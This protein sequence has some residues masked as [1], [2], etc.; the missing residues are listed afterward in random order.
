MP[1]NPTA[2]PARGLLRALATALVFVTFA[3]AIAGCGSSKTNGTN[4]DPATVVPATA[5]LYAG[6]IVRP[7][8]PLKASARAAGQALTHQ[9]NP[10]LRLLGALQTPGSPAL[11]YKHDVQPWL[12]PNA[13]AFLNATSGSGEADV[14]RLLSLLQQGLLGGSSKSTFPFGTTGVQGAIVLDTSDSEEASSFLDS[15][16]KHAGAHASSYRGVSYQATAGDVALGVVGH[17]A[18]IGSEA[19]LHGVIDTIQ[20]G[21]ALVHATAYSKLLASAPSGVLAHVYSNVT[22]PSHGAAGGSAAHGSAGLLSLLAGNR[23][24]NVSL[25]P[26]ANS[27]ALD[28]DTLS[29]GSSP[30]AGG[31]LSSS[32][33]ASRALGELP[34]ESWF[35]VGLADAGATLG[36]DAQ[37]LQSLASL[38]DTLTGSDSTGESPSATLSVKGL[39]EGFLA[40]LRA[41]GSGSAEAKRDFASWMGSA[42]IF[43]SGSG[44]LELQGGVVIAS[45]D[46]ARS[47]AAVGKLAAKLREDGSSVTKASVPGTEAAVEARLSGLPVVLFIAAGRAANGQSK[48]VM[49]LGESSVTAAL[50]PSSTLSGSASYGTASAA[51]GEDIQPSLTIDFPTLLSLLEGVGLNEDPTIAPFVPYLRSLTT[52]AGGGKSLGEDIERF[53]LVLTLAPSGG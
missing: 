8:E 30:A 26:S 25:V 47:R 51:L 18:V 40:P 41:L 27:I 9:A 15:Q 23:P 53:R 13:G 44:L 17:F 46:P 16:A 14:D 33:E 5:S 35:A 6:A 28:A 12:G 48:F 42:G 37:G 20:G 38:G 34:G 10:Y 29:S 45:K 50:S 7:D 39:L 36:T 3:Y 24:V 32:A 31:L 2:A 52:L 1:V 22:A 19:G 4:A 21:P 11:D 49:G 43:A